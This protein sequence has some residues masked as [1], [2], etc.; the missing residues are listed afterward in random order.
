MTNVEIFGEYLGNK[1]IALKHAA[2]QTV[3]KTAA[4][5]DNQG[6]GSSFS[7]TDLIAAALGSCILTTMAIVAERHK[8][9]LEKSHFKVTKEMSSATPRSIEALPVELHLPQGLKKEER[10]ILERSGAACPVMR[11]L[12]TQLKKEIFFIYDL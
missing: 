10:E 4:P 7:P 9:S 12:S 6:D 1:K 3:I 2:S 11:S 8:I 5:L